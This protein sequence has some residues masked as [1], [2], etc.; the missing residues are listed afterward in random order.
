MAEHGSDV[1]GGLTGTKDRNHDCLARTD[2]SG[3]AHAV[4]DHRVNAL[5]L[6]I[7]D[8]GNRSRRGQRYFERTFDRC[9]AGID[10]DRVDGDLG[11]SERLDVLG[12]P[13]AAC[14]DGSDDPHLNGHEGNLPCQYSSPTLSPR[15][16]DPGSEKR[17]RSLTA[18]S[19]TLFRTR[20]PRNRAAVPQQTTCRTLIGSELK[21]IGRRAIGR[22]RWADIMSQR[23]ESLPQ[24][25][26]RQ[27]ACTG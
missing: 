8:L 9:R 6:G 13:E 21:G 17:S 24:L 3:V 25:R 14:R 22:T 11:A 10:L 7:D 4:N 20:R 5:L 12:T 26:A 23:T 1:H 27:V 18:L 15:S 16:A 19:R 2:Q